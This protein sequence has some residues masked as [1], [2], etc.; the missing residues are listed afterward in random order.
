MAEKPGDFRQQQF[1]FTA[2]IR[3]PD[4]NRPPG[5]IEDRRLGIYRELLYRNVEIFLANSFPVLRSIT[6][7]EAWHTMVRKYFAIHRARTPLFPKLPQ[8]FLFFLA[9]EGEPCELPPYVQELAH[10]EWLELEASL[11][12]RDISDTDVDSSMDCLDGIPVLNPIARVHSYRYPV[13]QISPS[14]LP[15]E[16]TEQ[17]TYLVVYRDRADDVGFMQLN[18]VTARLVELI[19]GDSTMSGRQ[20]LESIAQEL[21]H[22]DPAVVISGGSEIFRE[23]MTRDVLLGAT[24]P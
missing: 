22:P 24:S 7:D 2:H 23:L 11:D 19:L 17:P 13:H 1:E 18:P 4:N 15:K 16:P 9:D 3:D 5:D 21:R 10:Y 8:E 6:D 12:K 14:F 20:L